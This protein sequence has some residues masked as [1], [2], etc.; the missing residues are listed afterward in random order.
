[1]T[2]TDPH[3]T[4]TAASDV[5]ADASGDAPAQAPATRYPWIPAKARSF[6]RESLPALVDALEVALTL[7]IAAL[8]SVLPR[9]ADAPIVDAAYRLY[10]RAR[11]RR[12]A[13]AERNLARLYPPDAT[14][15]PPGDLREIALA[16][17]RVRTE[18]RWSQACAVGLRPRVPA[19][20]IVGAEHLDA[21]L[22]DGRGAIL[23]R[24]S[25][26]NATPL[27][28]AL[29]GRGHRIAHLS[30][31]GH[32]A[33]GRSRFSR[34]VCSPL[35][36]IDEARFLGR[37]VEMRGD[38]ITGYFDALK[39]TLADNGVVSVVGDIKRGRVREAAPIGEMFMH[40]PSGAPSLA[41]STGAALLPCTAVR[42]APF[43]YRIV[44]FEDVAAPV[45]ELSKRAFREAVIERYV[46]IRKGLMR[47]YPASDM[48]V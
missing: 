15:A 40:V 39:G 5:P 41:F 38:R 47:E 21:A 44:I 6:V 13:K 14:D 3:P 4:G 22:G 28:A 9:G 1:M 11:P 37:R 42:V 19:T 33:T 12:I 24:M 46:K 16:H 43:S 18:L 29:S 27:N 8:S 35:H 26:T 2:T 36:T 10:V 7:G 48:H 45:R 32:G 34:C 25:F 20:E 17:A 31:H 23:W 30:M